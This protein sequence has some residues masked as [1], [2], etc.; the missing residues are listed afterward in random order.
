MADQ[1]CPEASS[2]LVVAQGSASSRG[3]GMG[4]PVTSLSP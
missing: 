3:T 4:S 2:T 1:R